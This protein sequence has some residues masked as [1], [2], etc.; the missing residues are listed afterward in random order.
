MSK[1]TISTGIILTTGSVLIEWIRLG[2]PIIVFSYDEFKW[3]KCWGQTALGQDKY[4]VRYDMNQR[5][6]I[7]ARIR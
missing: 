5:I 3:G 6:V 7:K 1:I 4:R 2:S